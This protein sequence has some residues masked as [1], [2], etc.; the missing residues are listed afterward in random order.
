MTTKSADIPQALNSAIESRWYLR[1]LTKYAWALFA[2]AAMYMGIRIYQGAFALETGLDST[3]PVFDVYWRRLFY[4]EIALEV[5]FAITV[6]WYLWRTRDRHLELLS[7]REEIRRYFTLVMWGGIYGLAVYWA[8]SYFGEQ[9][10]AWH[11]AAVRD[12]PLTPNHIVVFYLGFPLYTIM[13]MATW[14]YARTRL[15]LYA[16]KISLPL[17]LAV[18]GPFMLL[19]SVGY[20]EWGHTFWFREE[21]FASPVHY[22]FVVSVWF[23]LALAGTILQ[24]VARMADLLD[25]LERESG[26]LG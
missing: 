6:A 9:D 3:M 11:Q 19:P 15:P 4:I 20:N 13:G 22:G 26:S 16:E 12:T 21:L 7:T 5:L 18:V 1:D 8:G 2:I 17:T 14:L 10:N 23:A 24:I 25:R